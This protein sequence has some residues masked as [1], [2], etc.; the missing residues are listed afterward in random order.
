MGCMNKCGKA[1]LGRSKYCSAKCKVAYNRNKHRIKSVTDV[2]V[3]AAS[4]KPGNFGQPD[5][6]CK[7]CLCNKYSGN[8]HVINHGAWKPAG[9]LGE[10]EIN[11][12][13]LPG[14]VD[15]VRVVL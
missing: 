8:K 2:T 5:C 4:A 12:V 11:R 13:A 15:Y 6:E 9:E 3:K 14:D 1:A 10:N 7:D